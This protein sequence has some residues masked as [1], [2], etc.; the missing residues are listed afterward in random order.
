MRH[1]KIEHDEMRVEL[2]HHLL[3][4]RS[5]RCRPNA[6]VTFTLQNAPQQ[7]KVHLL[8]VDDENARLLY[9]T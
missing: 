5:I 9:V 3:D 8:V 6:R 1:V 2:L 7:A 4:I